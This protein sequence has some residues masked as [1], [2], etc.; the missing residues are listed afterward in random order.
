MKMP[1]FE[2]PDETAPVVESGKK[3]KDKDGK[4]KDKDSKDKKKPKQKP[5]MY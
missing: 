1:K 5:S 2:V 3:D 4:D